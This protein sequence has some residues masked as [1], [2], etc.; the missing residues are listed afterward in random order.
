MAFYVFKKLLL[1]NSARRRQR[2]GNSPICCWP[3]KTEDPSALVTGCDHVF[4]VKYVIHPTKER[5]QYLFGLGI[6]PLRR[7]SDAPP[8]SLIPV[9][10]LK[11]PRAE[12]K[13]LLDCISCCSAT[14][15]MVR[16]CFLLKILL[17]GRC[18]ESSGSIGNCFRP[19]R[20]T[21]S[22]PRHLGP[23]VLV[24][25]AMPLIVVDAR[26]AP[27]L[28]SQ[29]TNLSAALKSRKVLI[30]VRI[31]L[32]LRLSF[33]CRS[34]RVPHIIVRIDLGAVGPAFHRSGL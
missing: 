31:L 23:Y 16:A 33:Q 11:N 25:V 29:W 4:F 17:Y 14:P 20:P 9:S 13:E 6:V 5:V 2:K 18:V 28:H 19:G 22:P 21:R 3:P 1:G 34:C 32:F 12:M 30:S 24:P 26:S 8:R 7:F 10:S 15:V 27:V